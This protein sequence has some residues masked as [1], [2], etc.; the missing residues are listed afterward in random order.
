M[1]SNYK[2]NPVYKQE[3]H[4]LFRAMQA[5]L[6]SMKIPNVL[7]GMAG[8]DKTDL[9]SL[10]Q[11]PGLFMEQN[12]N[13]IRAATQSPEIDEFFKKIPKTAV[14][15]YSGRPSEKSSSDVTD[16]KSKPDPEKLVNIIHGLISLLWS[17][18]YRTYLV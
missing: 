4:C 16:K 5:L 15:K 9:R 11:Q 18:E 14:T 6:V 1:K 12:F 8:R 10:F 17:L 7:W 3:N 13:R 2:R